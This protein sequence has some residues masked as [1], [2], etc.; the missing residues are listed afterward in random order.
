MSL[1]T[2]KKRCRLG[3][4]MVSSSR[5]PSDTVS[6]I[7]KAVKI[8]SNISN[9]DGDDHRESLSDTISLSHWKDHKNHR[10]ALFQGKTSKIL[11]RFTAEIKT[12][13][14]VKQ[15]IYDKCPRKREHRRSVVWRSCPSSPGL[16]WGLSTVLSLPRLLQKHNPCSQG[17][18]A[19][20]HK[21]GKCTS[22][23]GCNQNTTFPQTCCW[24]KGFQVERDLLIVDLGVG[25]A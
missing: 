20:Q 25:G 18:Q 17:H 23:W 19:P 1:K 13:F 8:M 15:R 16:A 22:P 10:C 4:P 12:Y 7:S 9:S 3:R 6:Q 11:A 2:K 21:A 5:T 24:K 14:K